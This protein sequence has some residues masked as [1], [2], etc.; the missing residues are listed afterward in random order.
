MRLK[1]LVDVWVYSPKTTKKDGETR[2]KW[3]YK[4]KLKLNV[5][6]DINELDR[7]SAGLIDYDKIKIRYDRDISIEKNDGVSLTEISIVDGYLIEPPQYIVK[8]KTKVGKGLTLVC[9]INHGE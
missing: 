5:Q 8:S 7:N 6:Q 9:E 2:K 4:G 1:N 3:A